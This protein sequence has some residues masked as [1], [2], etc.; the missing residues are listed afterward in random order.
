MVPE[1]LVSNVSVMGWF[2]ILINVHG[3]PRRGS[4]VS[5][6]QAK[7]KIPQHLDMGTRQWD[8]DKIKNYKYETMQTTQLSMQDDPG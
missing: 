5:G 1:S 6:Q 8:G 7:G 3:E 2:N 4:A